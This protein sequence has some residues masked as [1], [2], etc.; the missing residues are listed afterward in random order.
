MPYADTENGP[1]AK[2]IPWW[3]HFDTWQELW[4]ATSSD[5][6]GMETL[7]A[8]RNEVLQGGGPDEYRKMLLDMLADTLTDYDAGTNLP[9]HWTHL[10]RIDEIF[11]VVMS[12]AYF[13]WQRDN[14]GLFATPETEGHVSEE[15]KL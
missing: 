12:Y 4:D 7:Q 10:D 1:S 14:T 11:E 6:G 2:D 5:P 8:E 15:I 13:M 3:A 9:D